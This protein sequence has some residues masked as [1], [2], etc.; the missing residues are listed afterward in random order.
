MTYSFKIYGSAY[1]QLLLG[2]IVRDMTKTLGKSYE[3]DEARY[4][5]KLHFNRIL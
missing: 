5:Q 3:V 4:H 2:P 1:L